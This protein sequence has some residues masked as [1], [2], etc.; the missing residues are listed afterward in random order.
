[1]IASEFTAAL[2]EKLAELEDVKMLSRLATSCGFATAQENASNVQ[3]PRFKPF[4]RPSQN[5]SMKRK[6]DF[7]RR[8]SKPVKRVSFDSSAKTNSNTSQSKSQNANLF[9]SVH[10]CNHTG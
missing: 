10:S 6:Q 1:M 2:E 4:K 3:V 5:I 9:I 7:N 8:G